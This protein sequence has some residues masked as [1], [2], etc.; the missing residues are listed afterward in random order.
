MSL[1]AQKNLRCKNSTL[2]IGNHFLSLRIFYYYYFPLI[3]FRPL[4]LFRVHKRC[5]FF[6]FQFIALRKNAHQQTQWKKNLFLSSFYLHRIAQIFESSVTDHIA[7]VYERV[8]LL[9]S[10]HSQHRLCSLRVHF[11]INVCCCFRFTQP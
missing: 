9:F 8:S 2:K 1:R 3:F 4:F 7:C 11:D 5:M 6:K 10:L